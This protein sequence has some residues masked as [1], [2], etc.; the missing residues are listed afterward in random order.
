ME[1]LKRLSFCRIPKLRADS[2]SLLNKIYDSSAV[3]RDLIDENLPSLSMADVSILSKRTLLP[4]RSRRETLKS[5]NM[6][7]FDG[8]VHYKESTKLLEVPEEQEPKKNFSSIILNP[9]NQ[10]RDSLEDSHYQQ[11]LT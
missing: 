1:R 3:M 5:E 10:S 2:K 9:N 6:K 8:H 4:P 11:S 7:N